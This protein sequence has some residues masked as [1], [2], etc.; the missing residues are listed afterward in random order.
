MWHGRPLWAEIDL[1]AI[2]SNVGALKSHLKNG[3]E[4]MAV[5]KANGYGHGAVQVARA[6][7]DGGAKWLAVNIADEGVELRRAGLGC[8][9]LV[10]GY[11]P[12]W[13]ADKVVFYSLTPT[14]NTKQLAFAL[15]GASQRRGVETAV[16]V[17]VD[18]GLGRFGLLPEEVVAFARCLD[19]IA[20][21]RLEGLWTHFA[22]SDEADKN[23]AYQQLEVYLTV[24]RQLQEAGYDIRQRHAANSG[25][26]LAIPEAHLDIVRCGISIY[27]LYPSAEVERPVR[28]R[29]AMALKGR[30]ARVRRFPPGSSFG[31]G[32]TAVAERE[33]VAALV[34]GGYGD[35]VRR[36][37]SN[38][39]EVLIR[40]QRARILGRVSMDQIIVDVTTIPEVAQDD[41]VV[42]LGRQGGDEISADEIAAKAGTINYDI[43]TGIAR[44]V[45]RLYLR[46]G[47]IVALETL[48]E[49]H[50][51]AAGRLEG[52]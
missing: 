23:F 13:E 27:G 1:D 28:L 21:L 20:N 41:E 7:L 32:R 5:V 16:H 11:I 38:V 2:R 44:R 6:S 8:P 45:P 22:T 46:A 50:S 49:E 9:I 51:P 26:T 43:V 36:S 15:A 24:L 12:P 4:L 17:K 19:S 29:P 34:P 37:L 39:G 33:V 10:L 14:V 48:V 47:E 18:T 35:G 25:A 42:L 3:A 52:V 30:V 31:Y 40:G